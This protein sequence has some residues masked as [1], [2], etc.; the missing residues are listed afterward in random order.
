MIEGYTFQK[1]KEE[2]WKNLLIKNRAIV[3]LNSLNP[4]PQDERLY[5]VIQNERTIKIHVKF[6][7]CKGVV[8]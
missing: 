3:W 5:K 8:Q 7:W 4:F 2:A 6:N 1:L